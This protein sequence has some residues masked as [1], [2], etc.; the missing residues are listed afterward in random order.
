MAATGTAA[1]A[2]TG[3]LL[4]LLLLGLTAPAAALAGYIEVRTGRTPEW[5]V[6]RPPGSAACGRVWVRGRGRGA[7]F[8]AAAGG[9][10]Q[11]PARAPQLGAELSSEVGLPPSPQRPNERRRGCGAAPAPY[12][13]PAPPHPQGHRTARPPSLGTVRAS[14]VR[15]AAPRRFRWGRPARCPWSPQRSRGLG[16]GLA[17]GSRSA[18]LVVQVYL[19]A[20]MQ[21]PA[22]ASGRDA[23]ETPPGQRDALR[24]PP[25]PSR[26]PKSGKLGSRA[27]LLP[28]TMSL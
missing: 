27:F 1:A 6:L 22:L 19:A 11:P 28:R 7:R 21:A 20:G 3:K 15:L 23:G 10:P 24:P 18:A 16:F 14:A 5:H 12:P 13:P 8:G 2:A 25:P 17:P 9:R 4:V 26:L